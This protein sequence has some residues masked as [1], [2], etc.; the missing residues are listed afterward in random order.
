[1]VDEVAEREQADLVLEGGG[2]KG[3]GL[4]GALS[5]LE[6]R[7][8]YER[9]AGTSAGAI[10]AALLAAG[11]PVPRIREELFKLDFHRFMDADGVGR[12][13]G[14]GPL[15]SL[16]LTEGMYAGDYLREWLGNLLADQNKTT[17]ADL[18]IDDPG[19]TLEP[20]QRYRLVVHTTDVTHGQLIRL[21]WDYRRVYGL[22]PD[23]QLVVDA[24]RASM[25]IPYFFRP[26]HLTSQ[27]EPTVTS[28]LVD[29]GALSNFPI[30]CFDRTDGKP[31]R[32]P[33]IGI[34][35]LPNLPAHRPPRLFPGADLLLRVR[36]P[37]LLGLT[38]DLVTTV[39]VGH[40]QARLA[41]PWVAART[42]RVDT[43]DVGIVDFG[44]SDQQRDQLY[45]HGV[46]AAESFVNRWNFDEYKR[47]FR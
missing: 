37:A 20:D 19:S 43:A 2:V 17:F 36:S 10:T 45:E 24:V 3:V 35:L 44:L 34:K 11:M 25:S 33:T 12:V 40:D 7:F 46:T 39:L 14:A 42:I 1:M 6:R 22:I 5:V 23:E 32:W 18:A 41:L 29:G 9:V 30:D 15:L 28:T 13:P 8:T 21:P 38:E 47:R 16:V 27:V 31:P 26:A 4:V